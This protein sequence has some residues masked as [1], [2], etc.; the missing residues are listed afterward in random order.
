MGNRKEVG[1][2]VQDGS[3]HCGGMAQRNKI[4]PPSGL[5]GIPVFLPSKNIDC[6]RH[7]DDRDDSDMLFNSRCSQM[8]EGITSLSGDWVQCQ[9]VPL[10]A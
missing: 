9:T 8:D 7:W 3:I 4:I 5:G 2:R 10:Q 6:A 1:M